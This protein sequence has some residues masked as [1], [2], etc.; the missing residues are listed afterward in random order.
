MPAS[1]TVDDTDLEDLEMHVTMLLRDEEPDIEAD[2]HNPGGCK[3]DSQIGK[4]LN[5]L[6]V[7]CR[8]KPCNVLI[9]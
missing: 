1:V 8:P 4:M 6:L 7:R 2:D 9:A 5:R 3:L